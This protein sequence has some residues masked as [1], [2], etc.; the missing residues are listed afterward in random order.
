MTTSTSPTSSKWRLH[1]LLDGSLHLLHDTLSAAG[2]A[3]RFYPKTGNSSTASQGSVNTIRP[4]KN[5]RNQKVT[6]KIAS[7]P[8]LQQDHQPSVSPATSS[9]T[10]PDKNFSGSTQSSRLAS[11]KE[12]TNSNGSQKNIQLDSDKRADTFKRGKNTNH[13]KS[14]G[15]VGK[16]KVSIGDTAHI[17][18]SHIMGNDTN[19]KKGRRQEKKLVQTE[20]TIKNA[21]DSARFDKLKQ[22]EGKPIFHES[23]AQVKKSSLPKSGTPT[24]TS[25]ATTAPKSTFKV[26]I[27]SPSIPFY[28]LFILLFLYHIVVRHILS[29]RNRTRISRKLQGMT[30]SKRFNVSQD[31]LTKHISLL[32][33]RNKS[34]K[35]GNKITR[36]N[37]NG[38]AA[39]GHSQTTISKDRKCSNI[40]SDKSHE[41]GLN[42]NLMIAILESLNL[43]KD[44]KEELLQQRRLLTHDHDCNYDAIELDA[45]EKK[46]IFKILT[47]KVGE[48]KIS[49]EANRKLQDAIDLI[50]AKY[51]DANETVQNLNDKLAQVKEQRDKLM[52][53]TEK[54]KL[55]HADALALVKE[56]KASLKESNAKVEKLTNEN[57]I[58]T[59]VIDR[60]EE[61]NNEM[62]KVI[63]ENCHSDNEELDIDEIDIGLVPSHSAISA[64]ESLTKDDDEIDHQELERREAEVAKLKTEKNILVKEVDQLQQSLSNVQRLLDEREVEN[65]DISIKLS[66]LQT[67]RDNL[68]GRQQ[69]SLQNAIKQ[70]SLE[71]KVE[72]L[73]K[74]LNRTQLDLEN[75]SHEKEELHNEKNSIQQQLATIQEEK[76]KAPNVAVETLQVNNEQLQKSLNELEAL[77]SQ[78]CD[79]K[80]KIEQSFVITTTR[81]KSLLSENESL[82]S[83]LAKER[84]RITWCSKVLQ[85]ATNSASSLITTLQDEIHRATGVPPSYGVHSPTS[86]SDGYSGSKTLVHHA[87][88]LQQQIEDIKQTN[89]EFVTVFQTLIK[90]THAIHDVDALSTQKLNDTILSEPNINQTIDAARSNS[91]SQRDEMLNCIEIPRDDMNDKIDIHTRRRRRQNDSPAILSRTISVPRLWRKKSKS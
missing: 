47:E 59:K 78:L 40:Q 30:G 7:R 70:S 52:E 68:Q 3:T 14:V 57:I 66:K 48:C 54:N 77:H 86:N 55:L 13:S 2:T 83:D 28:L 8:S 31:E 34:K 64:D 58:L 44:E 25:A 65:G 32:S 4:K 15:S 87:E 60:L 43:L 51:T 23:N 22:S 76:D 46:L 69:S 45:S 74:L 11:I 56:L 90:D 29:Y 33:E 16:L 89:Q 79:D 1:H 20:I 61:Q 12:T 21:L 71:S 80:S 67:E 35:V 19:T 27:N 5:Q 41:G 73:Q 84:K 10:S 85:G 62:E 82:Q 9:F 36:D 17:I 26:W 49:L 6:S 88:M 18:W 39:G 91:S 81:F 50:E 75:K 53:S 63:D 37:G 42:S 38:D 72:E 24:L